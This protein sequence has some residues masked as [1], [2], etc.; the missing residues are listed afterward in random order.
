MSCCCHHDERHEEEESKGKKILLIV[1]IVLS[2]TIALLGEF[3]FKESFFIKHHLPWYFNLFIMLLSWIIISYDVVISY[4]K[5]LKEEK[6]IFDEK[7]LMIIA[8]TGAFCLRIFGKSFDAS[9]EACL[10]MILYQFGEL[11]EDF[12]Q[13]KAKES[14]SKAIK[15][16]INKIRKI[17]DGQAIEI[18]PEEV[19]IGDICSYVTGEKILTDG[20]IIDGEGEI[21]ESSLTG[22]FIPLEKKKG[23]DVYS[24]SLLSK[25]TILV[26][27]SKEYKDSTIHK[28][29]ELIEENAS[30]KSKTDRFITRF[31]KIYTP[32][33]CLLALLLAII[34]PL[35]IGI[36][37]K[38]AWAAWIRV[39]L[40]VLVA[41]CPCSIVIS[42][43]LTYFSGLGLASK[44]G[45]IIK[46]SNNFD[47]LN[48][49]SLVCFDKTGTLT[50][51]R[52]S[53]KSIIP[54]GIDEDE[55]YEYFLACECLSTHPIARAITRGFDVAKYQ[56]K[57]SNYQEEA[58]K[59]VSCIY[60]GHALSVC[61]ENGEALTI[62]LYV[63]NEKKGT[64][65]F[66]DEMRDE[67]VKT[68]DSLNKD[69][70]ETM[71]LSGDKSNRAEAIASSLN[72]SY[73]K[74]DLKPEDKSEIIKDKKSSIKGSLAFIGDG[75]NDAPSIALADV[76]I[77]MG[78]MGSDLAI[79]NADVVLM[80]DDPS[81]LI[82]AR[83]I[84]RKTER[85]AKFNI[86]II[87]I[88][89]FA[90]VLLSVFAEIFHFSLPMWLAVASDSGLA[91]LT[92][93]FAAMLY[94]SKVE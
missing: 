39:G 50:K 88:V 27:V 74:G 13:D 7:A 84:A 12:A 65:S 16:R 44:Y 67:S 89:K 68:I 26:K 78:S 3:L 52:L 83:K 33:V 35:F 34:P 32:L 48:N 70:I 59:G 21:D 54:L 60:E 49:L 10:I 56:S 23:E 22:E 5:E 61:K 6:N 69:G 90:I 71:L 82:T 15:K 87:L 31:S 20:V 86:V 62:A 40:M 46:G 25:G 11:I 42:I 17:E 45:I 38:D 79:G 81:K 91:I 1:R 8:S 14:I 47:S 43:P 73:F 58:G 29:I 85:R 63:D 30:K 37:N 76:G 4:F 94:W 2:L 77:A 28:L 93:I 55:L 41:S 19:K 36:S 18:S 80:D 72:I 57:I 24:G 66:E 9:L 75:I 92:I 64:M 51:G 53:I